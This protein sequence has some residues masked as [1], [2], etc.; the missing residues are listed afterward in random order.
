MIENIQILQNFISHCINM[1]GQRL[2]WVLQPFVKCTRG[3]EVELH[4]FTDISIRDNIVLNTLSS[5]WYL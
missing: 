5:L 3:L 2:T 1:N 4:S